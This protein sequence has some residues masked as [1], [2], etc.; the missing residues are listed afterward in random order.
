MEQ[1]LNHIGVLGMKWGHRKAEGS[2]KRS[3]RS[4]PVLKTTAEAKTILKSRYRTVDYTLGSDGARRIATQMDRGV[5][6]KK[7]WRRE[8]GRQ[9]VV[10]TILTATPLL[11]VTAF[12]AYVTARDMSS[13]NVRP[14]AEK[15]AEILKQIDDGSNL[16]LKP[17]E[18]GIS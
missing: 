2:V 3:K 12:T 11:A 14:Y 17:S 4:K 16:W 1:E 18:Y 8:W 10:G 13:W 6:Y 5:S 7:A 15:A 9:A